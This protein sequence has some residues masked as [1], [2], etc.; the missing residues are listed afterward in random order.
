MLRGS[1]RV[2]RRH[3][4][5]HRSWSASTLPEMEAIARRR[6]GVRNPPTG[7]AHVRANALDEA[8]KPVLNHD[9]TPETYP[10]IEYNFSDGTRVR[11]KPQGD[12]VNSSKPM[13]SVELSD[14]NIRPGPP[15]ESIAFKFDEH[16]RPIPKGPRDIANPYPKGT[17]AYQAYQDA[18][19]G[20]GHL[21][22]QP[23]TPI[24]EK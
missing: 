14:T 21:Y 10:Q 24:H 13:Y 23:E 7:V 3:V 4:R 6:G 22:A 18:L 16:G 5:Y 2:A 1:L 9:G 19:L 12:N 11:L 20:A 17:S 8:N 15:Q